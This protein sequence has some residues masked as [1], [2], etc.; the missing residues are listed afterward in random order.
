MW[1]KYRL[2]SL[3][4]KIT[5]LKQLL[6]QCSLSLPLSMQCDV[7]L[8]YGAFL[9]A[10]TSRES[11][12]RR[13]G[14]EQCLVTSTERFDRKKKDRAVEGRWLIF[15]GTVQ[16]CEQRKE[17][18]STAL[19]W[20]WKANNNF[21]ILVPW[22]SHFLRS[23]KPSEASEAFL[24]FLSSKKNALHCKPEAHPMP[25]CCFPIPFISF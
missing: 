1:Q 21:V 3:L 22:S 17:T 19:G 5:D 13:R 23:L 9:T 18:R 12:W 4:V 15:S 25:A 6:H 24:Y 20:N 16:R 7:N 8:R 14:R 2:L 10:E 11:L